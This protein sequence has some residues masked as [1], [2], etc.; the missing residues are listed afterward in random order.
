M[1][2]E[3]KPYG[4]LCKENDGLRREVMH[5]RGSHEAALADVHRQLAS[6]TQARQQHEQGLEEQRE[7]VRLLERYAHD[8]LPR[9][10]SLR[11]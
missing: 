4:D 11:V 6:A 10:Q 9:K 5:L 7:R 3:V 1:Q 2:G 8:D